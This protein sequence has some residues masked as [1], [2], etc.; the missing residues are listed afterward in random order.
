MMMMMMIMLLQLLLMVL[1]TMMMGP[2]GGVGC[3]WEVIHLV[4]WPMG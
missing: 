4:R 2:W 1:M 3:E